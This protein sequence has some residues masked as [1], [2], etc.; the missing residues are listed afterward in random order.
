M[1]E[2]EKQQLIAEGKLDSEGNPIEPGN[3]GGAPGNQPNGGEGDKPTLT[4]AQANAMVQDRLRRDREKREAEAEVA[5]QEEERKRLEENAEFKTLADQYKA[6]LERLKEES[7]LEKLNSQRVSALVKAGY[8]DEQ[9]SRYG[10]YV[11]GE[12][13][14]EI[15][16]AVEQLKKDVPPT[17]NYVDPKGGGNPSRQTPVPKDKE[18]KGRALFQKLKGEGKLR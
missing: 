9:I 10:K 5:R 3:D 16:A 8:N 18:E 2:E 13:E 15:K 17:A 4:V 7:R 11:E 6:E 14:D 1:T 12:T